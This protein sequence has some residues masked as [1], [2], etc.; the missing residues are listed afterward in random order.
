MITAEEVRV[1][2]DYDPETGSFTWHAPYETASRAKRGQVAGFI[3]NGGYYRVKYKGARYVVHRLVWLHYY[4]VWPDGIVDHI[5][6]DK[7]NNAIANL[8]LATRSQNRANAKRPSTNTSGFKGVKWHTQ[9]GLWHARICCKG[10]RHSLGLYKN[11]EDA[12]AAYQRAA[13][14]MFGQFA[15]FA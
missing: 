7:A 9:T 8:R 4:G 13:A 5:D 2:F 12:H 1:S 15:R 3:D 11:P 6:G 10:K 14:E